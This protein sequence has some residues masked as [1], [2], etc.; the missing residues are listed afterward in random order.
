M[1]LHLIHP[2]QIGKNASKCAKKR[3]KDSNPETF[4]S[5]CFHSG[6]DNGGD[7]REFEEVS[8]SFDQND[9]MK[10]NSL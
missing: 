2:F 3:L 7:I 4:R 9:N 1:H 6:A 10:N 5:F 8:S